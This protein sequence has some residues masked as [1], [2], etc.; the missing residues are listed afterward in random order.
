MF[1]RPDVDVG[2]VARIVSAVVELLAGGTEVAVAFGKIRK[3]V[4][5]VERT[6]LAESAVPRAHIGCDVALLVP[7]LAT[8]SLAAYSLPTAARKQAFFNT[9]AWSI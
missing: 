9:Y 2:S 6:V 4:G 1:A 7:D 8:N 3:T 5:T